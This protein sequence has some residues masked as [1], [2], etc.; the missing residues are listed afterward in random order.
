MDTEGARLEVW[1]R[2]SDLLCGCCSAAV[3]SWILS[4]ADI[5][6]LHL[7]R[8]PSKEVLLIPITPFVAKVFNS[9]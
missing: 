6:N 3:L 1:K 5:S 9:D 8:N 2:S 7:C 4:L